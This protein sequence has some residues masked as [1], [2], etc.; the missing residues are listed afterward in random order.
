MDRRNFTRVRFRSL[1]VVKSRLS[2]IKGVVEDLSLNGVR[3]KTTQK[4]DLGKEVQVRILLRS[5]LS[6][7]WIEVLGV[8]IRHAVNGMVVQFSNMSLESYVHIRNVIS[9]RLQDRSKVFQEFFTHMTRGSARGPCA[10]V[11]FARLF[12]F[13]VDQQMVPL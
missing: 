4:L 10:E 8:V 13:Q 11:E 9:H 7:L 1:A 3:L 6:D 2:E 5:R 12:S